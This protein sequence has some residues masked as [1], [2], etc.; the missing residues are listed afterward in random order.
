MNR[1]LDLAKR[2]AGHVSPNPMVG[3]VLVAGDR[4][5]GEGYHHKH[6]GPHAEVEA[7]NSVAKGERH[8]ISK[9]TLYVNLEPCCTHGKTPPC[10]DMI[11]T[12][13]IPRVVVA[14]TDPNPNVNGRG[15]AQLSEAGVE[16]IAN[17]LEAE[18][19]WLNRRFETFQTQQRPYVILKWAQ[20]ADGFIGKE[21]QRVKISSTLSDRLVHKWRSEED[22]ILVGKRTAQVDNPQLT[23]RH[24]TGRNPKR[25]VL[26]RENNLSRE[27][28]LFDNSAETIVLSQ[29][30]GPAD[31]LVQLYPLGVMSLMV[32][33]GAQVLASFIEANLWDEARVIISS[34]T[35]NEGIKAPVLTKAV[36]HSQA[37]DSDRILLFTNS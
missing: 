27:L 2:G 33:G 10:T 3:A 5:I 18:A 23:V 4:V 14:M 7:V 36:R 37:L 29:A 26:D 12:E 19:R 34:G 28:H 32:E 1:C 13:R 20:S 8:L 24:W 31:I 22:A 16:V 25:V 35:L 6:G 11:L 9:S 30:D 17:V 21:G 15:L